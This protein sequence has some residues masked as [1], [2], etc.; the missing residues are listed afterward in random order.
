[1]FG[2]LGRISLL[3]MILPSAALDS[4]KLLKGRQKTWPTVPGTNDPIVP[5]KPKVEIPTYPFPIDRPGD[6]L[7]EPKEWHDVDVNAFEDDPPLDKDPNYWAQQHVGEVEALRQKKLAEIDYNNVWAAYRAKEKENKLTEDIVLPW[8]RAYDSWNPRISKDT[9]F[10]WIRGNNPQGQIDA[11]CEKE[12][13]ATHEDIVA[14]RKRIS[15]RNLE[16]PVSGAS[17]K[18]IFYGVDAWYKKLLE[19]GL[20]EI[21]PAVRGSDWKQGE[22]SELNQEWDEGAA[23]TNAPLETRIQNVAN[24][25]PVAHAVTR[26]KVTQEYGHDHDGFDCDPIEDPDCANEEHGTWI[27]TTDG[28]ALGR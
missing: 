17:G 22:T 12:M 7:Y 5:E 25:D 11:I 8:A 3:M 26:G 10:S 4:S 20:P 14:C 6:P 2:L 27:D 18:D 13:D 16:D 15:N 19:A 23:T 1:M 28:S 9:L 21:V 24:V